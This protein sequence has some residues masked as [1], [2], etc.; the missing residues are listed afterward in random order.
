MT[1]RFSMFSAFYLVFLCNYVERLTFMR[2]SATN[3]RVSS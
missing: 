1:Y 3:Y 2:I